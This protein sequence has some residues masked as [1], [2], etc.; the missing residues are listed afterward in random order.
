MNFC[1]LLY[2]AVDWIH[3]AAFV[4]ITAAHNF[5]RLTC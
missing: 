1:L 5:I 3:R 4:D 2:N